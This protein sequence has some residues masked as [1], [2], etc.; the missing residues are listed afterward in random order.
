MM[1]WQQASDRK[2]MAIAFFFSLVFIQMGHY[3]TVPSAI[4]VTRKWP[5]KELL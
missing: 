1:D 2:S 5:F 3:G 4:W